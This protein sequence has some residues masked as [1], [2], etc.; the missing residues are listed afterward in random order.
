MIFGLLIQEH[1]GTCRVAHL[2]SRALPGLTGFQSPLMSL[3]ARLCPFE[4]LAQLLFLLLLTL[5]DVLYLPDFKF[6]LLS[7][8]QLTKDLNL[9]V[10]FS[11]TSCI[12]QDNTTQTQVGVGERR[13]N[14]YIFK[15][16]AP[17]T[18]L[19]ASPLTSSGT[20]VSD[21]LLSLVFLGLLP[22]PIIV[23]LFFVMHV[24]RANTLDL[25]FKNCQL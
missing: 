20:S 21:I 13:H 8:S 18:A 2:L 25:V 9:T 3:L 11:H 5:H 17:V 23:F 10:I 22:Y 12:F 15:H 19:Q 16:T 24:K 6:N 1:R 7:V 4:P 14:L